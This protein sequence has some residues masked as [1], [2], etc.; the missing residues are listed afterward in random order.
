MKIGATLVVKS[1]LILSYRYR[2]P[3]ERTGHEMYCRHLFFISILVLGS[4][5]PSVTAWAGT[6]DSELRSGGR[7][8]VDPT[9]NKARLYSPEGANVPLWNGVHQLQDG[10]TVIVR[11]GV[12]VPNEEVLDLRD[13]WARD[14]RIAEEG[15]GYCGILV[16]KACGFDNE[17]S[18]A[19]ICGQARQLLQFA[20]EERQERSRPGFSARFLELPGQCREALEN[21]SY[22]KPCNK[23]TSGGEPT[24]C[25]QLVHKVCGT[26]DACGDTQIC[27]TVR[28]LLD[29]EYRERLTSEGPGGFAPS[30]EICQKALTETSFFPDC[31]K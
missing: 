17:C 7:I 27:V 26:E 14:Q 8:E 1:E 2:Y 5:L 29:R 22:F 12:M 25:A 16:R 24:F 28:E 30:A 4:T 23:D 19:S 18:D 21:E 10:S 9:T 3:Q 6:W 20:E 15:K 31:P 11:D 13:D